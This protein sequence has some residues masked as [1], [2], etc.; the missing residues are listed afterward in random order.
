M[1]DIIAIDPGPRQST[2]LGCEWSPLRPREAEKFWLRDEPNAWILDQVHGL[3]EDLHRTLAIEMVGN[4]GLHVGADVFHTCLWIGRFVEAF[5]GRYLLVYRKS[6][7]VVNTWD[8]EHTCGLGVCMH[9]CNRTNKVG[10]PDIRQALIDRYGGQ[11]AAVGGLR[12]PRCH[13]KGWV[14][15]GRPTCPECNGGGFSAKP[16][17]LRNITKHGWSALAVA[18]TAADWLKSQGKERP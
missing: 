16:G 9:L 11:D 14:G 1:Y 5:R 18:V 13:G 15:S 12:C 6:P 8:P 17:P 7:P 4:M 10:D 2:M 3:K